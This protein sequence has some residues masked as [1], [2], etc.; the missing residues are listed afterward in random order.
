MV[1]FVEWL[2]AIFARAA[3]LQT[4]GPLTL[5]DCL[6]SA[7]GVLMMR[8]L[9]ATLPLPVASV[10]D[11]LAIRCLITSGRKRWEKSS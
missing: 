5:A 7:A 3:L 2:T 10:A 9:P 8:R 6:S 1:I 4:L 11:P